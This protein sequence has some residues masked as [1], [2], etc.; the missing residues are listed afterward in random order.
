MLAVGQ[1]DVRPADR[2]QGQLY[3]ALSEVNPAQARLVSDVS[4]SLQVC[5]GIS[6]GGARLMLMSQV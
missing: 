5:L 2:T 4:G 3:R 1:N 6:A